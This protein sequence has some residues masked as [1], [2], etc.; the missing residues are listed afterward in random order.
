MYD[1]R[2]LTAEQIGA[3]LGWPHL[4]LSGAGH[5]DAAG[6]PGRDRTGSH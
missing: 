2:E 3:V 1:A 5:D 4:G 6:L